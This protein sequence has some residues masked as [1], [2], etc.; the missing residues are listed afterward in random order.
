MRNRRRTAVSFGLVALVVA[1]TGC[2]GSDVTS[3]GD[4]LAS[5]SSISATPAVYGGSTT[6]TFYP[7]RYMGGEL[8]VQI[9]CY[10]GAAAVMTTYSYFL[11]YAIQN[12]IPGYTLEGDHYLIV[13]GPLAWLSYA[14]G[15]AECQVVGNHYRNRPAPVATNSFTLSAQ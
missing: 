15:G 8:A 10:Q 6:V 13:M 3:A 4:V 11:D 5:R 12:D 7:G 2:G 9:T 1:F 14:G